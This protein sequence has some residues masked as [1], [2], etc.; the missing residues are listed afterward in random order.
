[1]F[2]HDTFHLVYEF[3]SQMEQSP[4]GQRLMEFAKS[5][6]ADRLKD[7]HFITETSVMDITKFVWSDKSPYDW[8]NACLVTRS[9]GDTW[10][11]STSQQTM[12]GF[13]PSILSQALDPMAFDQMWDRTDRKLWAAARMY[14]RSGEPGAV[15]RRFGLINPDDPDKPT[16][17]G[18]MF[19]SLDP[20]SGVKLVAS[21]TPAPLRNAEQPSIPVAGPQ[22][23]AV[24]SGHA[25]L[26]EKEST[27]LKGKFKT[28]G[29][30]GI[31]EVVATNQE[32]VVVEPEVELPEAM[33]SDFKIGKKVM[34]VSIVIIQ[35]SS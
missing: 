24:K 23:S 16:F 8:S 29:V 32:Q 11:H 3:Q 10:L 18:Y 2:S 4:F 14:D 17:C 21:T 31:S 27:K 35:L 30:D 22:D 20:A 19:K 13:F 5:K 9:V 33:P 28:R 15:A 1:M 7:P 6:D 34:K 12:W 26:A 25:Y